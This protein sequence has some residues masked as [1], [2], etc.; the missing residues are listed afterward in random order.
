MFPHIVQN[1]LTEINMLY[2]GFPLGEFE[3][4]GE[5]ATDVHLSARGASDEITGCLTTTLAISWGVGDGAS[6][7]RQAGSWHAGPRPSS[8]AC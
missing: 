4:N 8:T 2:H 5:D 6:R 7:A 3:S 1:G